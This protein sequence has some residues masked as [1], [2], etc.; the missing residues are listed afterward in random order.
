MLGNSV[1]S[2]S[3]GWA[4]PETLP[5]GVETQP[6]ETLDFTPLEED[7]VSGGAQLGDTA[8]DAA[9]H[10]RH[11]A[12]AFGRVRDVYAFANQ[13]TLKGCVGVADV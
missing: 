10:L 7:S 1:L 13:A 6:A 3:V 8:A 11:V 4:T 2:Q 12:S 5:A 9:G